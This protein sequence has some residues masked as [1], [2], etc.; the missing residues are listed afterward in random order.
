[1]KEQI[2]AKLKA[3]EENKIK[4]VEQ[5]LQDNNYEKIFLSSNI[6]EIF[7]DSRF[8]ENIRFLQKRLGSAEID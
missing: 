4:V 8:K 6:Y 5:I 1:M 3:L 2:E 7:A